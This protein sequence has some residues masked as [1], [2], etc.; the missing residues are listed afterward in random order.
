MIFALVFV[1]R[2]FELG[3]NELFTSLLD[4]IPRDCGKMVLI[5]GDFNT[6]LDVANPI[7]NLINCFIVDNGLH[8]CDRLLVNAN[9]RC[10][11]FNESQ[12]SQSAIDYLLVSNMSILWCLCVRS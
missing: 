10:T 6:D 2:D 12:G 11:Y 3:R 9:N 1:S 8:R 4:W 5:G 7:S